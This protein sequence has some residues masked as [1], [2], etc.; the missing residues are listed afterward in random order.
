M[1]IVYKHTCPNGKIYIGITSQHP[2]SRWRNGD[3]YI[4]NDHFYRAIK[5]YGWENIKHEILFKGLTKEESEKKEIELIAL[6]NSTNPEIG[7]NMREGGSTS[8]FSEDS[9]EKMRQSHKGQTISDEQRKKISASLKGRKTSKGMLGNKHSQETK[10]K[11][12]KARV[13][14]ALN[15]ETKERISIS[16]RGTNTGKDNHKS[17][18]VRN[19]E[20]GEIFETITEA[21]KKY[22]IYSGNLSKTCMKTRNKCGGFHWEYV[23]RRQ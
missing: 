15:N 21:C 23:E 2:N 20:T 19:I 14:R 7:Y 5:K 1:Y 11:M 4:S 10:E 18:A 9:I 16:K 12:R 17:R 3:G 6:Y 8:S 13:G 22:N